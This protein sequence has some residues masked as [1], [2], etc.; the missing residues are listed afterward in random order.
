MTSKISKE[1]VVDYLKADT[2]NIGRG[3]GILGDKDTINITTV[4]GT[5]PTVVGTAGGASGAISVISGDGGSQTVASGTA[6]GG[7]ARDV[8]LTGGAGGSATGTSSTGNGGN[9]ADILL[10][11]GTGG[12]TIGGT[13][14]VNGLI[15][16]VQNP[17]CIFDSLATNIAVT[18]GIT[19]SAEQIRRSGREYY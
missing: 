3:L 14:G 18:G 12:T 2:M 15:K 11:C 10:T 17:P 6:A 16:L 8:R 7:E 1:I 5:V 13:A 9:G 19:L 4:D